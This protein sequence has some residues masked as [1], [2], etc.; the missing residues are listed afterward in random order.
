MEEVQANL[1]P[2]TLDLLR[3]IQRAAN[4]A[5]ERLTDS[6]GR[7]SWAGQQA[8]ARMEESCFWIEKHA[9]TEAAHRITSAAAEKN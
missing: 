1:N 4:V 8:I 5:S 7:L 9:L 2:A 3:G 6:E